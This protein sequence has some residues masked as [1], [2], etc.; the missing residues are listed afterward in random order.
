[1]L[2]NREARRPGHDRGG[3]HAPIRAV[4]TREPGLRTPRK[5]AGTELPKPEQDDAGVVRDVSPPPGRRPGRRARGR[6]LPAIRG[7]KLVEAPPRAIALPRVHLGTPR[8]EEQRQQPTGRLR[9]P[10]SGGWVRHR[11]TRRYANERDH[12]PGSHAP[13]LRRARHPRAVQR[14]GG[15]HQPSTVTPVSGR[16]GC[17]PPPPPP[18]PP[19]FPYDASTIYDR[20]NP[21]TYRPTTVPKQED[22]ARPQ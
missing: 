22:R 3:L 2:A 21:L 13:F 1:M 6:R 18:P 7:C 12:T 16:N 4:A 19:R 5:H 14:R 17:P 20:Y 8:H 15:G 10:R 9:V 11:D